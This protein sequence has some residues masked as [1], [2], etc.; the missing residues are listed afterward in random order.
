MTRYY[1]QDPTI[2]GGKI[3]LG[4]TIKK[5]SKAGNKYAGKA[6]DYTNPLSYVLDKPILS[7]ASHSANKFLKKKVAPV[8][9]TV[10]MPIASTAL[11][12]L[13]TAYGGPAAGM[14]AQQLSQSLMEQYIPKQYQSQNKWALMA[15]D[16][17]GAMASQGFQD[18]A[19]SMEGFEDFEMPEM[20]PMQ[21]AMYQTMGNVATNYAQQAPTRANKGRPMYPPS[22][23]PTSQY[24][25]P[26]NPYQDL[27]LQAM[28]SYMPLPQQGL[29]QPAQ[30]PKVDENALSDATYKK[31]DLGDGAD[32][33]KITSPPFQQK[34]GSTMGLLGG[35]VKKRRGR[36]K[37]VI[38]DDITEHKIKKT[39]K[40]GRPK[41]ASEVIHKVEVVQRL[42]YQ[43]YS[44]AQNA[45]LEQMLRANE[46]KRANNLNKNVEA[47]T[48]YI[49][50]D[51]NN[52][53]EE[54]RRLEYERNFYK[55]ALGAGVGRPVKGSKEAKEKMARLRAMKKK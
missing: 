20:S 32:S 21:R 13:A 52:V 17:A 25:N 51:M 14:A 45:S 6:M 44:H 9:V 30:T 39:V 34:E 29:T 12:A 3:H 1:Y 16:M 5:I 41:K 11:G 35:G 43:H 19:G 49:K 55:E 8:A 28:K 47:M 36:P 24:Y 38:V 22:S 42:P 46:M 48:K 40:R 2:D 31:S 10:G 4:K 7:E 54:M 27:M 50:D 53:K 18:Y 37:K 33:L 26:E 15:G 23:I